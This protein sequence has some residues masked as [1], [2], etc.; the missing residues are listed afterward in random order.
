MV[1]CLVR[2]MS[3]MGEVVATALVAVVAAAAAVTV[4]AAVAVA[5]AVAVVA[6]V[7]VP[8]ATPDVARRAY[9]RPRDDAVDIRPRLDG[10]GAGYRAR[11]WN[12][13]MTNLPKKK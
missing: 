8:V 13:A 10:G 7:A 1:H 3:G 11:A 5:V 4:A 6:A 12:A 9:S 2:G